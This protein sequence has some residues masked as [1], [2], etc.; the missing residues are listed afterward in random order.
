M[1]DHLFCDPVSPDCARTIHTSEQPPLPNGRGLSPCVQNRFDPIGDRD[2]TN[3]PPLANQIHHGPVLLALLDITNL[4][5][6]YLSPTQAASE[7]YCQNCSITLAFQRLLVGRRHSSTVSQLP[8]R[9]PSFLAPFTRWM[10]AASSGLSNPL[11][12]AGIQRV[13][14]A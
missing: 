5:F 14:G 6:G 10:P 2:G 13:K 7:Q 4:E 11:S 1:P 8:S 9:T 12:A 3:M